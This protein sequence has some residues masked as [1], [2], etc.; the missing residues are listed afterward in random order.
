MCL[1]CR[2]GR[3]SRGRSVSSSSES[4]S[5]SLSS[6]DEI[7]RFSSTHASLRCSM[8]Q[9]LQTAYDEAREAARFADPQRPDRDW[10]IRIRGRPTHP[11]IRRQNS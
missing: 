4:S 5:H 11:E 2:R 7:A 10:W 9:R 1:R 6:R 8:P 3:S